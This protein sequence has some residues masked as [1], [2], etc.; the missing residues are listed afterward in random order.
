MFLGESSLGTVSPDAQFREHTFVIPDDLARE[1]SGKGGAIEVRVES[2]TWT[3][4]DVV[5]GGD[6]RAL[7]V[8]IDRAEIH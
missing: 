3:P 6:D 2:T 5:G 1:L 4:R 7:G 8:M